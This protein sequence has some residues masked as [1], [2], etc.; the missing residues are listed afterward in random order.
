LILVVGGLTGF[1]GSNATEALVEL[2]EDCVVTRHESSFVPAYL[3]KH[4]GRHVFVESADAT[5]IADLRQIGE[6]HK[7]DGI[8]DAAGGLTP[9][10]KSP[11]P[12]L[13]GYFDMLAGVFQLAE[14]WKV[15]RLMF[16][17]TAGIYFGTGAARM[18]EDMPVP[19]PSM[20]GLISYQKIVEVACS[21]F[22]RGTGISTVCFRL[23]GM[24]GPGQDP[25]FPA[26]VPRLVHAAVSGR[27]PEL[28]GVYLSSEED[29]VDLTYI[30]DVAQAI[31]L[32]QTSDTLHHSVY[33]VGTGEETKSQDIVEA[34]RAAVPGFNAALN[35][36]RGP[37]PPLGVVDTTRLREDTSFSPAFDT[38][39]GI[40]DYVEWLR[41]GNP[42]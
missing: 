2:G 19:L 27:P 25:E 9:R 24:F 18:S 28:D 29:T 17:S 4:I 10:S 38:R 15:K 41:A 39:S 11:V 26:L 3:E 5:S 42:R 36:G 7:I 32:L 20:M 22:A 40:Y 16:S 12:R 37:I 21:E 33:N 14:E 8:V 34:T 30:K 13:K 35:P 6:K 23:F 1:V 31:A